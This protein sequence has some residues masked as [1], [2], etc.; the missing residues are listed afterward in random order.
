MA[1]YTNQAA[2]HGPIVVLDLWAQ[3]TISLAIFN[4]LPI[5]VLDGGHLLII[6]I[7][8]FRRGRRLTVQQQQNFMIAGLAII[9]T[10]FV[11][12]TT[13]GI[14]RLIEGKLPHIM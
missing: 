10:L 9:A 6:A 4:L 8:G 2:Q 13:R 7:E 11:L 14:I 3:L 5:P 1:S 12:I